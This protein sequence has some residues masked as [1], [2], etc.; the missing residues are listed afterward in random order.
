MLSKTQNRALKI[1][2]LGYLYMP[3]HPIRWNSKTHELQYTKSEIS[4]VTFTVSL[5]LNLLISTG[6][7]YVLLTHFFIR[8]RP[9]YNIGIIGMHVFCIIA[10]SMPILCCPVLDRNS[11]TLQGINTLI[12]MEFLN[13]RNFKI[14]FC[15]K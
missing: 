5:I 2:C 9:N 3:P 4:W 10:T 1:H 11:G 6:A 12:Q 13:N 8:R 7:A 15:Y 14:L